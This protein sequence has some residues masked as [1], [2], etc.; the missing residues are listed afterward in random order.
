MCMQWTRVLYSVVITWQS[1]PPI[2]QFSRLCNEFSL[3]SVWSIFPCNTLPSEMQDKQIFWYFLWSAW[4]SF[5]KSDICVYLM[6]VSFSC[7]IVTVIFSFLICN[8]CFYLLQALGNLYFIHECVEEVMIYD[9][10]G[11]LNFF[12]CF[13]HYSVSITFKLGSHIMNCP[14]ALESFKMWIKQDIK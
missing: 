1:D 7:N 2:P 6:L 14:V 4:A 10:I 5:V 13:V 12:G 9:F 8:I 3:M 11:R